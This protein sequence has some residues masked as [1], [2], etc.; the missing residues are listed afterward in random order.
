MT[1]KKRKGGNPKPK[2]GK[3]S[4]FERHTCKQLS[5]WWTNH[6]RDDVFWRTSTSGARATTRSKKL[7]STFGQ[8]GDVQA[9]DPIGQ[10]LIDLCIIE[11]KKGYF[12][13]TYSDL[14]DKMPK[15]TKLPYGQFIQQ[16]IKDHM[17]AQS[18]SWLLITKRDR[19]ETL[20]AMPSYFKR[21]L[22]KV[23]SNIG[24]STPSFY[25]RCNLETS[26]HSYKIFVM[27]LIDFFQYVNPSHIKRIFDEQYE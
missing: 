9:T 10:P 14:M 7:Q 1:K 5:L 6:K 22:K 3:G 18:Y 25:F 24:Y 11:I 2:Q 15:E 13:H 17:K 26:R 21:A 20:V 12:K 23:G 8:H 4:S 16:V 19:K 27:T